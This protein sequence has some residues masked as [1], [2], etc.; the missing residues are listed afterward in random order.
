[1][2]LVQQHTSFNNMHCITSSGDFSC[3]RALLINDVFLFQNV[4]VGVCLWVNSAVK[5]KGCR[6]GSGY[7]RYVFVTGWFLVNG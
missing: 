1:V 7:C 4:K 6:G 2:L 5:S 3:W